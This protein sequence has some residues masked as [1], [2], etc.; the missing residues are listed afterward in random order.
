M[1]KIIIIRVVFTLVC[2]LFIITSCL[3]LYFFNEMNTAKEQIADDNYS[4]WHRLLHLTLKLDENIKTLEDV[5]EFGL[6]ENAIIYATNDYLIPSFNGERTTNFRFLAVRYD[7]LF[8]DLARKSMHDQ[9]LQQGFNLF[10][11]MNK[12]LKQI[13]EFVVNTEN[14]SNKGKLEIINNNSPLNKQLQTK[15]K[16]FCDKYDEEIAKL[17]HR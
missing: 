4:H 3:S 12:E 6:Y 7:S 10:M 14:E 9:Y 15:I 8:Q 1:K 16:E 11:E 13:C 5:S 17:Q 2:I